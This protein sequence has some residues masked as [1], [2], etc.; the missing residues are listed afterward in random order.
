MNSVIGVICRVPDEAYYKHYLYN[1]IG[2]R[3]RLRP[4]G[5]SISIR[6][7]IGNVI[8]TILRDME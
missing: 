3:E 1:Y 7:V 8:Y 5:I 2:V 6:L 4:L